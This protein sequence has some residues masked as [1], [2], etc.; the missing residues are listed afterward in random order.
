MNFKKF[1]FSYMI[2]FFSYNLKIR[3]FRDLIKQHPKFKLNLS[4][5]ILKNTKIINYISLLIPSNHI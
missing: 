3:T 5:C 4:S 2:K 1:V